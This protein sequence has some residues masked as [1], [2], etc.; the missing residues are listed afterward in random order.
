MDAVLEANC[1]RQAYRLVRV[2]FK[3][4]SFSRIFFLS[5][6]LSLSRRFLFF[7]SCNESHQNCIFVG[8]ATPRGKPFVC[9][10]KKLKWKIDK[11]SFWSCIC[12]RHA[13]T[14]IC[15]CSKWAGVCVRQLPNDLSQVCWASVCASHVSNFTEAYHHGAAGCCR[16]RRAH[17]SLRNFS[18]NMR[19]NGGLLSGPVSIRAHFL[20]FP[21]EWTRIRRIVWTTHT[22][23]SKLQRQMTCDS[24]TR[25]NLFAIRLASAHTRTHVRRPCWQHVDHVTFFSI[26]FVPHSV[27][28]RFARCYQLSRSVLVCFWNAGINFDETM[29]RR[30]DR[31]WRTPD[32]RRRFQK[33]NIIFFSLIISQQQQTL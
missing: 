17:S 26:F 20:H 27:V 13:Y 6:A 30:I 1:C 2:D 7:G 5:L 11:F 33:R 8:V 14:L 19:S 12:Q 29:N 21:C 24:S 4:W 10:Q 25:V 31:K 32:E 22:H 16:H 15:Y 23:K 9:Q 28:E 18:C 3:F